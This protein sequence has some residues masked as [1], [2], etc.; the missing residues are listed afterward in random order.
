MGERVKRVENI[1][2]ELEE[3][4][5]QIRKKYTGNIKRIEIEIEKN[6]QER[7]RSD[8]HIERLKEEMEKVDPKD[9]ELIE[10]Y[11]ESIE[12]E[13]KDEAR[14]E[15]LNKKER[16]EEE[17]REAKKN[18]K[19]N[20]KKMKI[21]LMGAEDKTRAK[22]TQEG[23]QIDNEIKRKEA[24][25]QLI[26]ADMREFKYEY[27]EVDGKRIPKNG[28]EYRKL[29]EKYKK[30]TDEIKE[31]KEAK[32]LC[33]SK[34]NEF[35]QK[36]D[37]KMKKFSEAW[38]GAKENKEE[39]TKEKDETEDKDNTK[40]KNETKEKNEEKD[41]QAKKE[42]DS[43]DGTEFKPSNDKIKISKIN[44]IEK[45]KKIICKDANGKVKEYSMKNSL[46]QF[47]KIYKKNDIRKNCKTIT[48]KSGLLLMAKL[49]PNIIK[50]L[51]ED[52]E[53]LKEYINAVHNKEKFSAEI[54]HDVEDVKLL[55]RLLMIHRLRN[56]KKIGAKIVGGKFNKNKALPEGKEEKT[57]QKHKEKFDN[58]KLDNKDNHIEEEAIKR[59]Q[60]DIAKKVQDIMNENVK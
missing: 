36:D 18:E 16:L 49:N 6:D 33:E 37:E 11:K 40:P 55:K 50:V 48:G 27:E 14:I 20:I 25:M 19:D 59:T 57:E 60:E 5:K 42:N 28:A 15:N 10:A 23:M 56:E 32:K 24:E 9:H 8:L 34:L 21:E 43:N 4:Q 7:K 26:L 3:S 17:Y 46:K 29:D 38:N 13:E 2:K 51:A 53:M 31:L 30:K 45:D 47:L 58:I 44:I 1:I 54:T 22:L 52:T 39:K 35:K 12:K 41:K